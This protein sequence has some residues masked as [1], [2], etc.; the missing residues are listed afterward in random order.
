MFVYIIY[1][2]EEKNKRNRSFAINKNG[3]E[4]NNKNY[5]ESENGREGGA[6]A[7]HRL[8]DSGLELGEEQSEFVLHTG[9]RRV[10]HS[11]AANMIGIG[12][13]GCGRRLWNGTLRADRWASTKV[14]IECS[15]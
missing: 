8:L 13:G 4:N 5:Y 11:I 10:D 6:A 9:E 14:D 2:I 15:L 3:R 7:G 12:V 1:Y